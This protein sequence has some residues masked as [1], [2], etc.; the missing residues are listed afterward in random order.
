MN[1]NDGTECSL[2]ASASAG[3]KAILLG[4]HAV[5]YGHP[6]VAVPVPG[7]RV[8]VTLDRGEGWQ[9]AGGNTDD[10]GV[11][12]R[13]RD[14]V[15][16]AA[17]W[18]GDI[19]RIRTEGSL[20]LSCGLGSSAAL[21][22]ALARAV[23]KALGRP[24]D[25]DVV[26]L[27]ANTSE[28]VFHGNPSGV[29]VATILAG[30]PILFRK[31]VPPKPA[32]V[33]GRFDL[34][35]VDSGVRSS[36]A[37]VVSSVARLREAHPR[38]LALA[39]EGIGDAARDGREALASGSVPGLAA[40]MTRAM[41]NL[42]VLQVSHPVIE[43]VAQAALE[44]GAVAVKLSGAGQGGVVLLL[45]PEPSWDPGAQIAGCQVLTRVP[46]Q[47]ASAIFAR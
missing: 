21:G 40:A 47:P 15:L 38:R 9:L 34:W 26:R 8:K 45:G 25:P 23:L 2:P 3:G 33:T 29:D 17:G 39:L 24:E 1:T 41:E 31:G 12:D 14:A 6:A 11:L 37:Q 20:P 43:G 35:V 27:L 28:S 4:E 10:L 19:P 36:T 5:V 18:T 46:I 32:P 7:L 16:E 44:A 22:V 13:A 42:R 30:E